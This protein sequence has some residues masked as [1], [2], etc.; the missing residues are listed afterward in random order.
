MANLTGL[1]AKPKVAIHKF[2]SCDGCQLAFLNLGT[3]LLELMEWVDVANFVEAGI[4]DPHAKVDIA[5][6]EGSISTEA[7]LAHIQQIREDSRFLIAM[8]ACATAGGIQALRNV[9]KLQAWTESVYAKPEY[10]SSLETATPLSKHVRVDL[11]LWGCP[12]NSY[13]VLATVRSFLYGVMPAQEHDKLCLECKRKNTVCVMV[14]KGLPCMGPVTHTGCGSIC[15]G[16]GRDCY[17][18]YGPAEN[19]N[20]PAF[21]QRL[22]QLGLDNQ[23]IARRFLFINNATPT[24][25]EAGKHAQENR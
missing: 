4:A 21:T 11:E 3:K 10:I 18:C 19:C 13:Q 1:A 15:P 8:G 23:Q 9:G 20:T 17:A 22:Q 25:A 6:V 5:F 12:I 24:F 2:S 14:A 7:E 16:V